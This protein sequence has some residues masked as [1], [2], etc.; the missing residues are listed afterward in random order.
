MCSTR[1]SP[2]KRIR[3]L[4]RPEIRSILNVN[5]FLAPMP[6]ERCKR[7]TT[8]ICR[9][10]CDLNT[11]SVLIREEFLLNREKAG[12]IELFTNARWY[13]PAGGSIQAVH[14]KRNN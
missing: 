9:K 12:S 1:N 10:L 14:Y 2:D 11:A 8:G 7:S 6:I 3:V 13:D 4:R 5:G